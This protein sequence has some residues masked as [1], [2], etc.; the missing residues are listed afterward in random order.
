M[1]RARSVLKTLVSLVVLAF[2]LFVACAVLTMFLGA[3]VAEAGERTGVARSQP[4]VIARIILPAVLLENRA[5]E[6]RFFG[7]A[8]GMIQLFHPWCNNYYGT[9][10]YT[11]ERTTAIVT[12]FCRAR[13]VS[14]GRGSPA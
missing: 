5:D 12:F 2:V 4:P 10:R 14:L 6:E 13:G 11:P 3:N 8:T 1:Y 9:L 7:L